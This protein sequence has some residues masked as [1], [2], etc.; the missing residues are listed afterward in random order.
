M[1]TELDVSRITTIQGLTPAHLERRKKYVTA[2]EMP[3]LC[4]LDEYRDPVDVWLDKTGQGE[5]RLGS[6][7]AAIGTAMESG[8]QTLVESATGW[9]LTR[10]GAWCVYGGFMGATRD[11]SIVS[12]QFGNPVAGLVQGKTGGMAASEEWENE[13]PARVVIQVHAEMI[14]AEEEVA[15]V[16]ALLGGFG[17][18]KF[19]MFRIERDEDL[20]KGLIDTAHR[21]HQCV[22]ENRRPLGVARLASLKRIAAIPDKVAEV[23]ADAVQAWL[24]QQQIRKA[25]DKIA[26]QE[27]DK[28]S[29]LLAAIRDE[30]P[31]AEAWRCELGMVNR[32]TVH[33]SPKQP[34][35]Y[36]YERISFKKAKALTTT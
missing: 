15:Y 32:S 14:C 18:L 27:K 8:L 3:A 33:V 24:D 29:A 31:D 7:P 6:E 30:E 9:K 19:R 16:A 21:F 17:P 11:W 23:P 10:R 26:E 13:P 36:S 25:A 34:V 1:I 4:G 20:A 35:P 5:P 22:L 12:D 2:S 28:E